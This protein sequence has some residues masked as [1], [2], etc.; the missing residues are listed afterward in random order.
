MSEGAPALLLFCFALGGE[1]AGSSRWLGREEILQAMRESE[2]YSLQATTNGAR[3]QAETILHLVQR[4]G[5]GD[6]ERR[7]L[8]L[9]HREWFEAYLA[10]AG[11]KPDEAPAFMRLAYEHGQD[12][13]ID[14]RR[15]RVL[16]QEASRGPDHAVN[17]VIWWPPQPGG[18]KS[19]SYED[20]LATPR[21]KVTNERV[22]TYRLLDFGGMVLYD[23]IEGLRGRPLTGLL[24]ML[25]KLIGEGRV[26]QS[27]MIVT[28]DGLQI[29]RARAEKGLFRVTSTV[30][31]WP[32][33]RT[34]K[35]LPEQRP[36]LAA[37]EAR[38]KQPLALRYRPL[39][40]SVDR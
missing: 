3:F 31:V 26:V 14:Y 33:G 13:E 22:I 25:F 32:D 29:S 39:R 10:R 16:E 30:T 21:L 23:E 19:Y 8:R 2:G 9:D 34:E 6:P 24:G 37:V 35:D 38:L 5:P 20:L 18:P 36:D 28:K 40:S 4:I 17:V 7:P 1:E 12:I 27:R 11:L 15:E